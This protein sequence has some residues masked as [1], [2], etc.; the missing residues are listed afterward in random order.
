M[1]GHITTGA[2][3]AMIKVD[4]K[5]SAIPLA[6]LPIILAVAGAMT[7]TSAQSAKEMCPI[8][9]GVFESHISLTT[10]DV[11]SVWKVSG[12]M[13]RQADL[14]ITTLTVAPSVIN[15]LASSADL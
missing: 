6:I 7:T 9:K 10:G 2:Q 4:K 1:A 3:P 13:N 8:S 5:S 15:I 12:V 14:V 11:V